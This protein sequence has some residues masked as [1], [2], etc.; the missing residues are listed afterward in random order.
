MASAALLLPGKALASPFT[1]M[2]PSGR[3]R[4]FNIHTYETINTAYRNR[5]GHYNFESIRKLNWILRCHHTN[6][7]Y[8][9]DIRTLEY[10]D[11]VNTR[12]GG[13]KE[14]HVISG[15]R[16]PE[17]N[18]YLLSHGH[19]VGRHSLHLEGRAIDIRIPGVDLSDIH[20]T[21]LSLHM[22]GVGYYPTSDFVHID[23]GAFR[24]W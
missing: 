15:Y 11:L 22:G 8:P 7:Q 23:S 19:R 4:L 6:E 17:Y 18:N 21:A 20:G 13:D 10:L 9:I 5:H 14:I 1:E 3:L 2:K 24:T 12:L 16:S